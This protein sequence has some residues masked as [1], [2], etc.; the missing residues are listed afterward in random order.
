M[1]CPVLLLDSR[2]SAALSCLLYL[3]ALGSYL[4]VAFLGFAALPALERP[5]SFLYPIVPLGLAVP[6]AVL[7]GFNPTR[8]VL[9]IYFGYT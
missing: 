4:Y 3:G 7:A 1:A 9:R 6:I 8:T 2:V 5:E